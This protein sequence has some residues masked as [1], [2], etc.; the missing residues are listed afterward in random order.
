MKIAPL[1]LVLLMVPTA[2]L[3]DTQNHTT[4]VSMARRVK[5]LSHA[6]L[7]TM[8][9]ACERAAKEH[10]NSAHRLT[11]ADHQ[12]EQLNEA[13]ALYF[14]ASGELQQLRLRQ[15]VESLAK[16]RALLVSVRNHPA[17]DELRGKAQDALDA[18]DA[19]INAL[20]NM[21]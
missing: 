15:G 11:G 14:A 13:G 20:G 2:T 10:A 21:K 5:S 7:A 8:T 17:N 19:T 16:S 12:Q 18:V 3:A 9:T 6:E 4:C 1:V